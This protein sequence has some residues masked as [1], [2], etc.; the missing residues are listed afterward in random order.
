M[1]G[2]NSPMNFGPVA[3]E[4]WRS[5]CTHPKHFFGRPYFVP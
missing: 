4:I 5:N 1:L 3:K 2:K